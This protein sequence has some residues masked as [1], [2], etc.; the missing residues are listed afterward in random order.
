MAGWRNHPHGQSD[1][2]PVGCGWCDGTYHHSPAWWP[3]TQR[4]S[5]VTCLYRTPNSHWHG[6]FKMSSNIAHTGLSAPWSSS[7]MALFG[8]VIW[9]LCP[10]GF[11]CILI[12]SCCIVCVG[13]KMSAE[14]I[15]GLGEEVA[16]C[17]WERSST[18]GR[19]LLLIRHDIHLRGAE[20][21]VRAVAE[22]LG[23]RTLICC[24]FNSESR[25]TWKMCFIYL[26][27]T[28][29]VGKFFSRSPQLRTQTWSCDLS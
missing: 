24:I 26:F 29:S 17:T 14:I 9:N 6:S 28:W 5:H 8:G 18:L 4:E 12:Q 7:L 10:Q 15:Q 2:P 21:K 20:W 22:D 16:S 25:V 3:I 23:I 27:F 11:P 1:D 19:E 13:L